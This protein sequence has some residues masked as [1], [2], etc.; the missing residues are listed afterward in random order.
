MAK[1]KTKTN[2]LRERILK[3]TT[4]TETAMLADS[5]VFQKK[6]MVPTVVPMVNVAL[7]GR[8]DGG[9]LPGAV[10]IAGPSKHFKTA[11]GLLLV[12][13]FLEKYPEGIILF[14]DSEFGTPESYFKT[15]NINPDN[16]IHCPVTTV[17][18]MTHDMVVQL[19]G[20]SRGEHV[21]IMIDSVGNLASNKELEDAEKG[22][23]TVDMTRAKRIKALF[24][25]IVPKLNLK[26]IPLIAINH[27]YKT[28]E[29][30][31]KDVTGGG[32]GPIYGANDIWVVGRQQD[33]EKGE[34]LKGFDFIINIE[35]SR[36][37]KE[38]S[39]IPISV[40]FE[41]GIKRWSGLVDLAIEAG[42]LDNSTKG[43]Y[44]WDNAKFKLSDIENNTEFWTKVLSNTN[45]IEFIEKKYLLPEGGIIIE[46]KEVEV[47]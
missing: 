10:M 40:S 4:L 11:F 34:D 35:K 18:D 2:A 6:D 9:M 27:T 39:K 46:D 17:E 45:L 20:L 47:A 41:E 7:S 42:I 26:A 22:K 21:M 28:L 3:N 14:Y 23:D 5:I 8:F 38:K 1:V 29:M 36:T 25:M 24:R 15:F 32:T 16:V 37:I 31:S 43:S 30:F 13:A 44:T 12:S 19:N 33:K